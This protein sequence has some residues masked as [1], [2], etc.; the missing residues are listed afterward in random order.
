MITADPP[1]A[2][3]AL[4]RS[5]NAVRFISE[6][7]LYQGAPKY[8]PRIIVRFNR[9]RLST[10]VVHNELG[11]S[12]IDVWFRPRGRGSPVQIFPFTTQRLTFP[13]T[14]AI[15]IRQALIQ[16]DPGRGVEIVL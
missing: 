7:R 10:V 9:A 5:T 2:S 16:G 6:R 8:T 15:A 3:P 13:P 1:M 4:S 12:P 11:Y 14:R